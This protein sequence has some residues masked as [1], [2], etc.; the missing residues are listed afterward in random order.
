MRSLIARA[1]MGDPR[2]LILDEPSAGLD[3]LAREQV[4]AT[5]SAMLANPATAPTIMLIMHHVEELP[6][7]T[8]N[9]LLLDAGTIADKGAPA[10]VLKD[11]VLSRVYRCPLRVE[12]DSGRYYLR[13]HPSAWRTLLD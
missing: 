11:A 10:D 7:N 9:V 12:N 6:P 13:V 3:L 8:S 4:L 2:L 5:V 1:M